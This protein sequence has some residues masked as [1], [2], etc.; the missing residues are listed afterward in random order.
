MSKNKYP[1]ISVVIATKNR[2]RDMDRC[3]RAFGN[4]DY[5][6]YEIIVADQGDPSF[7]S[8][9]VCLPT[10]QSLSTQRVRAGGKSAAL[11]AVTHLIKGDIVVF[12]DD[13]CIV[14][15]YWLSRIVETFRKNSN[16]DAVFGQTKPY[17]PKK[18]PGMMCPSVFMASS[19]RVIDKPIFHAK[20]IGFGNNMA[21]RKSVFD[22]AGGFKS[23]LG[24]GSIG[25]NA[26]DGEL[27]LRML[28][29]GKKIF[30][31]PS[32]VVFHNKWLTPGET[33]KQNLSY[34]C[35][36][37]ACYGYFHFQHHA[38]AT[39]IVYKNIFDIYSKSKKLLKSI[40][41]FQWNKRL[42]NAA[43]TIGLEIVSQIR[44]LLV[45]YVFALID[46]IK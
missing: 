5:H 29:Q 41:L 20:H 28:L 1:F 33:R 24:P 4:S 16:V 45:G 10:I 2:S 14:S 31:N 42:L 25:S 40:L 36:E 35:G 6:K 21:I 32:I 13:D 11:S 23:W 17:Q 3:L 9:N 46:P 19:P 18:H 39:P 7:T 44:G 15:K 37:M 22:A 43:G 34:L 27:A 38:F 30:Y 12:T 8:Q 26:E